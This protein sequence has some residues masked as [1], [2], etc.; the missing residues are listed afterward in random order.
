MVVLLQLAAAV[1]L[2]LRVILLNVI[3]QL[4]MKCCAFEAELVAVI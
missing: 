2:G 1:F 4:Y 3:L